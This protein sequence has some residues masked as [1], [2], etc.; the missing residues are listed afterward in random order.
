MCIST[1]SQN[2]ENEHNYNTEDKSA[3]FRTYSYIATVLLIKI[4]ALIH[5]EIC[6]QDL[7]NQAI[8]EWLLQ[9]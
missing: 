7:P 8:L 1:H 5:L 3:I 6:I 9:S 2:K 4:L